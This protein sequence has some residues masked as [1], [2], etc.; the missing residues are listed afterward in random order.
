MTIR[1]RVPWRS[2]AITAAEAVRAV[3]GVVDVVSELTADRDDLVVLPPL[4]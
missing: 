4:P 3:E 2:Q 1:G